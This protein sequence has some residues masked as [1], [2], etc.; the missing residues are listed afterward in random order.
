MPRVPTVIKGICRYCRCNDRRGCVVIF[1]AVGLGMVEARC[2]WA[3]AAHTV[4]SS[5]ECVTQAERD[6]VKLLTEAAR[7]A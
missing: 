6:G 5:I 7:A 4:C 3:D 2:G 1:R